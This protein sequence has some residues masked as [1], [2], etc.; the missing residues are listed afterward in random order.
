MANRLFL[1]CIGGTGA[2]VAKSLAMLLASGCR[3]GSSF[4][5]V[6]PILIDPDSENG[7]LNRTKEILRLYQQVRKRVNKPNDFFFHEMKSLHELADTEAQ[8]T[9]HFTFTLDDTLT[10][11][12]KEF[13]GFNEL[14]EI[15]KSFFR[16]LYSGNNLNSDLNIGFKGNPNMGSIVLDQFTQSEDFKNFAR[17]FSSGDSIFIVSSIFGGTGAAGFPLLLKTLRSDNDDIDGTALLNNAIVGSLVMLPYFK[18]GDSD[19]SEIDSKS[20]E[21][22]AKTAIRYYNNTLINQHKLEC[23]YLLGYKGAPTVYENHEGQ[24]LQ[25]NDAHLL[26]FIGAISILDYT[27]KINELD[28][29]VTKIKEFGL[30]RETSEVR[31]KD[32]D[33]STVQCVYTHLVKYR[34]FTSYLQRGLNRSVGKSRWSVNSVLNLKKTKLTDDFFNSAAYKN[35]IESFSKLFDEWTTELDR[36]RPSFSPFKSMQEIA[37]SLDF[38]ADKE[39]KKTTDAFKQ[40]DKCNNNFIGQLDSESEYSQL[41]KL[42]SKSTEAVLIKNKLMSI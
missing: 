6:V 36:N 7:D 20:F 11:T 32:L 2:R 4:D 39:I 15:D 14:S 22:K 26:E 40:I 31:F 10:N 42:F 25:K 24:M 30:Q 21:E 29:G 12:F 19:N 17:V 37:N 8:N 9:G 34:L 23:I 35:Y 41:L 33:T 38:L 5:T 13:I 1:F 16:L 28:L 3:L 27:R 18:V